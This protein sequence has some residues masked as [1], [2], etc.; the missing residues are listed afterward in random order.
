MT[1]EKG[2]SSSEG[3]SPLSDDFS[4]EPVIRQS[5]LDGA[6][7][8]IRDL[9]DTMALTML[10]PEGADPGVAAEIRQN[11]K[12]LRP[13]VEALVH[14]AKHAGIEPLQILWGL[15]GAA[16]CDRSASG[17]DVTE[18]DVFLMFMTSVA[19]VRAN[20]IRDVGETILSMEA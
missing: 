2:R 8:E 6:P 9:V 5:I 13:K 7:D 15:A 4:N 10:D 11:Y 14:A 17:I 18:D 16:A 20:E 19:I 1:N 12:Y 3:R